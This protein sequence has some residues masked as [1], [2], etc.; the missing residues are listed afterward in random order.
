MVA[1][2]TREEELGLVLG[3]A[4]LPQEGHSASLVPA[5]RPAAAGGSDVEEREHPSP[6]H[7]KARLLGVI[8]GGRGRPRAPGELLVREG[9]LSPNHGPPHIAS[10]LLEAHR[11]SQPGRSSAHPLGF[12]CA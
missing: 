10:L 1:S 4:S 3:L 2:R 9:L 12:C 11:A 6:I 8:I 5:Q 7:G